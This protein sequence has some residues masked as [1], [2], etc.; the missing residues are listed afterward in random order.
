[1]NASLLSNTLVFLM[2]FIALG[3][4]FSTHEVR[5]AVF[6]I[7]GAIFLLS[8][9]R[10]FPL[11][12]G[13]LAGILGSTIVGTFMAWQMGRIPLIV[14][15]GHT[16]PL[17]HASLW[18]G[19]GFEGSK[20]RERTWRIA[21]GFVELNI[22]A[23]L[24]SEFYLAMLIFLF[25]L[26]AAVA[27]SIG[28]LDSSIR[29]HEEDKNG[30][31]PVI[32]PRSFLGYTFVV[33]FFILL[34]SF[35]IFPFLPRV[36]TGQK[37]DFGPSS[38]GYT[39]QVNLTHKGSLLGSGGG[40]TA[41]L[42]FYANDAGSGERNKDQQIAT[43]IYLGLLRGRSL[44]DFDGKEWRADEHDL[45][46]KRERRRS[47][48]SEPTVEL[49]VIRTPLGSAT[50]PIPYGTSQVSIKNGESLTSP[51]RITSGEWLDP[52]GADHSVSYRIT[53]QSS[54]LTKSP[55]P[56]GFA[57]DAEDQPREKHLRIPELVNT[58]RL[59]TL[60]R[61]LFPSQL[62]VAEKINRLQTF[63][64]QEGFIASTGE[65]FDPESEFFSGELSGNTTGA[66]G[67]QRIH[68][69]EKFLFLTKKGHCELFSGAAAI[70]LRMAG[71]PTRMIAGFRVTR[72]PMGDLLHVRSGDG[73]AWIEY[74]IPE[75]GWKALDLT[76]RVLYAPTFGEYL[77]SLYDVA[78]AAWY[79][80]IAGNGSIFQ[81]TKLKDYFNLQAFKTEKAHHYISKAQNHLERW[82]SEE[83][84]T[85][86]WLGAYALALAACAFLVI[87]TW[88]PWIL[89]IRWKVNEGPAWIKRERLKMEQFL[90]R[91]LYQR[92]I[93]HPT[94]G[95]DLERATHDMR[96]L[97]GQAA[98]E[99]F[100]TW[101]RTYLSARFGKVAIYRKE[102]RAQLR[103]S[104]RELQSL[105][106]RPDRAA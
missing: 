91:K 13:L 7:V 36:E 17:L 25:S 5:P 64:T 3:A 99:C 83:K 106:K 72:A 52:A 56:P 43:E 84:S 57:T 98:A 69:I 100:S 90:V 21:V 88:F 82:A 35:F 65:G 104:Y 67:F 32:I 94:A 46:I 15:V 37:S 2:D 27:L 95:L 29:E 54:D 47:T 45:Q 9:I 55:L 70:L 26:L 10:K 19:K 103:T 11:S 22:T 16:A 18:M 38:V 79:R 41:L 1:M 30:A 14:A 92:W 53:L 101:Q 58:R 87:R 96:I 6:L 85:L 71:I 24:S 61:K 102:V 44:S 77:H 75:R 63:F 40:A 60:A 33:S 23:V 68:E 78:S 97:Y 34:T 31:Q 42:L 105:L 74:W 59:Q 86:L 80:G 8:Q 73:H 39:E 49:E 93:H 48:A 81:F 28:F 89:S 66:N 62:S 50:L 76:P 20:A 12:N 51:I 4:L